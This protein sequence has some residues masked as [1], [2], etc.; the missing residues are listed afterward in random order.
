MSR[1]ALIWLAWLIL[2]AMIAVDLAQLF[3]VARRSNPVPRA[4]GGAW[5]T[6]RADELQSGDVA[7][8]YH[9][10]PGPRIVGSIRV[11]TA[12]TVEVTTSDG[13]VRSLRADTAVRWWHP[14]T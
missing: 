10:G 13:R 1:S 9:L 8:S 2:V 5:G 6:K 4:P 7:R 14:P 11:A 12:G 3:W